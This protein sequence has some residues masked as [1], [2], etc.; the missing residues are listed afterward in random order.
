VTPI[1]T[2]LHPTDFS[3]R[4]ENAFQLACAL[5][6]DYGARLVVVH[7]LITPTIARGV[8]VIPPDPASNPRT[9][10]SVPNAAL[11]RVTRRPRSFVLP[12]RSAPT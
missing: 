10:W 6:R 3:D 12:G 11:K 5:T 2:I 4:S 1:Q 7:V 8:G 9:I